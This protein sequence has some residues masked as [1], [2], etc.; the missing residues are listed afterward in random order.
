MNVK[1]RIL[2]A[3]VLFFTGHA[4][5]AQQDSTKTQNIEEVVV[6]GYGT[7]KKADVT[8]SITTVKGSDIANLNT[9]TF[10]AQ[11]A[12]R[13]SGVQV[14]SSSGDIGRAPTVRIR[15]VN[16]ISSGTSPL[17][18]VDGVPIFAGDTGGGN[19]FTNALADINPSDIESMTVL[20]DGAATAIYGS[21]AANGVVLITTK[22]GKNGRFSVSY[23]N[24]FSVA[25]VAKKNRFV[26]DSRLLNY[27]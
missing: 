20:K 13:A 9:P 15:G 4:V 11:L 24:M 16:T 3:G 8:S 18:V 19:T 27:L 14:I 10:E 17:Y 23:N 21:R 1:L 7:Q 22:K 2:T 6:V 25:S 5:V 12:G 26:A